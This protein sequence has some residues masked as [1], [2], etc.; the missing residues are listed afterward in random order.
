MLNGVEDSNPG[1][2]CAAT[3]AV[4]AEETCRNKTDN[5]KLIAKFSAK[6][7]FI[8]GFYRIRINYCKSLN[9]GECICRTGYTCVEPAA[10]HVAKREAFIEQHHV[11]P[12]RTLRL[13]NG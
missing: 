10:S 5:M 2:V 3:E 13:V 4:S 6:P 8:L 9:D 11:V 7:L 12:L 1:S